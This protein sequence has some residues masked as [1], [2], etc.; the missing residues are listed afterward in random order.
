MS[1]WDI[2]AEDISSQVLLMKIKNMFGLGALLLV[3]TQIVANAASLQD[4]A[5]KFSRDLKHTTVKIA[6]MDFSLGDS[7]VAQDSLVVR[8]RI[9]TY[10][11]QNKGITLIERALLEKIFQ[12][13]KIQMSGAIGVD[14][15]KRIGELTGASAIVSGTINELANDEV[16]LNARIIEVETGRVISAGQARFKK[17]WKYFKPAIVDNSEKVAAESAQDYYRR[18][19]KYH[20]ESKHNIAMEFYS[21]AINLKSDYV[22]AYYGRGSL[23]AWEGKFNEAIADF[24]R[25]IELKIDFTEAYS[26]RAMA[27]GAKGDHDKA[28]S[29][30][31][32]TIE[33]TPRDSSVNCPPDG[34]LADGP[35]YFG[36][37]LKR[38]EIYLDKGDPNSAINDYNKIIGICPMYSFAY[39][40]R[41]NAY[42]L[43]GSNTEAISDYTTVIKI[44]SNSPDNYTGRGNIY[45][46]MGEYPLAIADYTKA[47]DL[48]LK[49]ID[50]HTRVSVSSPVKN[51]DFDPDAYL[52]KVYLRDLPSTYHNRGNAYY[53]KA[54][55]PRAISDYTRAIETD[56][57][58]SVA[59]LNRGNIYYMQGAVTKALP[60]FNRAIGLDPQ[61]AAAYAGRGNCYRFNKDDGS[62]LLDYTKAIELNPKDSGSY[63]NRGVIHHNKGMSDEAIQDYTSA[64]EIS[65]EH[66]GAYAGRGSLYLL[67][68]ENDKALADLNKA[69]ELN[70]KD[71][72][73]YSSR[74]LVNSH[75]M[76]HTLAIADYN[77]A[78]ALGSTDWGLK[79]NRR[80]SYLANGDYDKVIMECTEIIKKKPD[81]ETYYSRSRAYIHKGEYSKAITDANAILADK[82]N[83]NDDFMSARAYE[84]KCEASAKNK[85]YAKAI[86]E[87]GQV[88]HHDPESASAYRW[89]AEAYYASGQHQKAAYDV[90]RAL[91]IFPNLQNKMQPLIDSLRVAGY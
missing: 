52:A 7:S 49:A 56:P 40:L 3:A 67:R 30:L 24:N 76:N 17:D 38:G 74:G 5:G 42:L 22:D 63:Y 18:G 31:N 26:A 86:A 37:Y 59:Y 16:E 34:F 54:D 61:M 13:Q 47:I 36:N 72:Y 11:A 50:I 87:C 90:N 71:A 81:F 64:I 12:E 58:Y 62:A 25:A 45:Y 55:Y 39:R 27:Y 70:P 75:F 44:S 9:T 15:V 88:I 4:L 69:I 53:M 19:V 33:L 48:S 77:K 78:I 73:A 85:E 84:L 32:R 79:V 89:R 51:G 41:G 6:V 10:L 43:K 14:T 28:L 46:S 65:P 57:T 21:K 1:V 8:E 83:R 2:G 20:A 23:Y 66:S 80:N 29:D 35:D 82:N 91:E 60:D 68:N